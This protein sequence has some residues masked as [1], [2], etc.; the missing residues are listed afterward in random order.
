MRDLMKFRMFCAPRAVLFVFT[1]ALSVFLAGCPEVM[2]GQAT[3]TV[4]V[5]GM[6]T[7][8]PESRTV[9]VGTK[10]TV[11]ATPAEGW[12]FDRWT[13]ATDS[14]ENP[15][16]ITV[17]EDVKL[18]AVFV[19][20]DDQSGQP[21]PSTFVLSTDVEGMGTIE[22][23][24]PGGAYNADTDVTATA[25]PADGWMFTRWDD[26]ATGNSNPLMLIINA[27]IRLVAVFAPLDSDDQDDDQGNDKD[28][29]VRVS[30]TVNTVG[31]GDVV[32]TPAGGIYLLGTQVTVMGIANVGSVF[33]GWS[34]DAE[35]NSNPLAIVLNDDRTITA[36]FR[37]LVEPGDTVAL[38]VEVHGGGS[39]ALDPSGGIYELG[40]DVSATPLPLQNTR[41]I[42]W[43]GDAS[44]FNVPLNV[45]MNRDKTIIAV[46]ENV[47]GGGTPGG[48]G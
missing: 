16:T 15:L 45:E 8:D 7:V 26:A 37:R 31:E 11:T 38:T 30:L 34:G 10:V 44:G 2:N 28:E 35:G 14:T 41:F 24:P 32:V 25:V 40:T 1:C 39:V 9:D 42:R 27:D 29:I 22:L 47:A 33:D 23:D 36:N 18:T 17:N 43:E 6:G 48:G 13:G 46:F 5:D 19:E 3:L 21:V 20:E 12:L 4:G